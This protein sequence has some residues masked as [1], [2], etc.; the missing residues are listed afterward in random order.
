[1]PS[2]S[3]ITQIPLA[4]GAILVGQAW[5]AGHRPDLPSLS[6]QDPSA[7]LGS[8]ASPALKVVLLG[9]S[10]VTAPGVVPLDDCW[11]RRV[12][13]RLAFTYRVKLVNIAAGG[14][15]VADVLRYQVAPAL[16]EEPDIALVCVGANDALRA[17]SVQDFAR[18]LNEVLSRLS[19]Q[20]PAVGVSGLGD[21][22][23]L[24]R[25][26]SIGSAWARVRAR[27]FDRA[28]ARVA[29]NVDVPKT[30]AWGPLFQPF[31]DPLNENGMYAAD[32]FHASGKGHALFAHAWN[33][34]VDVLLERLE[35]RLSA[36]PESSGSST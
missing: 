27:S 3:A 20:I 15:R 16:A 33:E 28:I 19:E 12:G 6:N 23:P 4:A 17:V 2:I 7:V 10:S 11:A 9:D 35:T 29:H 22:G 8:P 25:L 26:P 36:H 30:A 13:H 14:S 1:M 32:L 5:H 31:V 18:D 34:V 24:P 21:L